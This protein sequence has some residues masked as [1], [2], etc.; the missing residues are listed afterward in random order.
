[1][2][3]K[4]MTMLLTAAMILSMSVTAF[5]AEAKYSVSVD[6]DLLT[7][8][9]GETK[10]TYQLEDSKISLSKSNDGGIALSF[11]TEDEGGKKVTLGE[12]KDVS[13]SG[14][15]DY[16][17]ISQ[18][19]DKD[20]TIQ[21]DE[22]ADIKELYSDGNAQIKVD[23]EISRAYLSSSGAKLTANSGSD[24][25]VVYAKN[26]NSVKGL[27]SHRV[28]SYVEPPKIESVS[29]NYDYDRYYYY[30]GRYYRRSDSDLGVSNVYDRGSSV[31]FYCDV[32]G[33][34]VRW[35][36]EKIGTTTKGT[37]TFDVGP[38]RYWDDKLTISKDGYETDTIYLG[39]YYD[40]Y[41]Y[42]SYR[43]GVRYW[44]VY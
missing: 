42:Y 10:A 7:V 37:N 30:D 5:A 28:K 15:I 18:T 25:E 8:N 6:D 38:N 39:D 23:G 9:N 36:G 12:Q 27:L 26:K 44:R 4:T 35:N 43:D 21:L 41:H 2:M 13:I 33:A 3:K 20:Y 11:R 1:M 31:R 16:L 40:D 17:N 29:S 14:D 19:L 34:T 32:S 24:V 22:D